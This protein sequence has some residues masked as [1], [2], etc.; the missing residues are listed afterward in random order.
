MHV[1]SFLFTAGLCAAAVVPR[2]T[3]NACTNPS[4]RVEWRS[5]SAEAK[6]DYTDAVLCLTK[7]P[8]ELGNVGTTRYDD[9][10]YV[11]TT[12]DV[13]IH[14]VA[15]FLPWHRLF[16]QAYVDALRDCNF[17][18]VMPY[19]DWTLDSNDMI[20]SSI[21]DPVS[22][23]GGNGDPAIDPLGPGTTTIKCVLDGPFAGLQVAW[24]MEGENPHC[25]T[26][27]W[28]NGTNY[29]GDMFVK[30][31]TPEILAG[32]A[33]NNN[34]NDFR[35][36]LENGPHGA[37]HSAI[38][39]DMSPATAPNDPLFFLH[40]SQIDR[41]WANWQALK[42]ETRTMDFAG[43]RYARSTDMDATLDDNMSFMG[44]IPDAKVSDAMSIQ[45]SRLCY[46]Y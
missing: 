11:H 43:N 14:F 29:P 17:K 44:L 4:K 45:T 23:F 46:S 37:V 26:R 38:G 34:F 16:V 39:G 27:N 21:W 41:L 20:N 24:V 7:K 40:H 42:P 32:V 36:S 28:N 19:W 15:Q 13:Q 33:A 25:L 35:K 18:G 1:F 12:M 10:T 9:F 30:S 3:D 22:G 5:L 6:K 2:Q 31:Y 8:S